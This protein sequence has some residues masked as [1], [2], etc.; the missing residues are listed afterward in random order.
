VDTVIADA[1]EPGGPRLDVVV[2][3][4]RHRDH[5]VGFE[6]ADAWKAVRVDEVW[7]PWT[8][9]PTDPEARRIREAQARK[10]KRLRLAISHLA[11]LNEDRRRTI[12]EMVENSDLTNSEAMGT[13]HG[14]F[15][16][17][18]AKHF[19]PELVDGKDER[20]LESAALPGVTVHV[21]GPSRRTEIIRDMNPPGDESFLQG[22][23]AAADGTASATPAPFLQGWA[24]SPSG[25]A[26]GRWFAEV[27]E[28]GKELGDGAR[29][30]EDEDFLAFWVKTLGLRARDLKA[31]EAAADDDPFAAAV[32]L[33]KAVNGTS[34]M[35]VFEMR[36]TFLLFPGDAQWGTWKR[37]LE[38]PEWRELLGRTTFYKVGHHGSHNAT[39]VQFVEE[40]LGR[41][42]Q[43]MVSTKAT[44]RFEDIPRPP[45]LDE[46][47]RRS[48]LGIV[49]SDAAA[50]G[51][52]F[53]KVGPSCI[54]ATLAL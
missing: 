36:G 35:L 17:P 48:S 7:M 45:L 18:Q 31:V 22:A 21:L 24:V 29:P 27:V 43:A 51:P 13:L 52:P 9:H 50:V 5:V 40:V 38:D 49:R 3:S 32:A 6:A 39:P 11:G 33:D 23:P 53:R 1:A 42:F 25:A 47:A 4:H 10:A 2:C 19:L 28:R 34:L 12:L 14:G 30:P 8:E 37:A 20:R 26:F 46:L 15:A 41:E 54:E 44:A 16:G